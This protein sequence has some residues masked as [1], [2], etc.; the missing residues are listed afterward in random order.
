[1]NKTVCWWKRRSV[2]GIA[3]LLVAL[4]CVGC[5]DTK[6]NSGFEIS[7]R[8]QQDGKPI[9]L[10]PALA[11]VAAA[12]VSLDVQQYDDAGTLMFSTSTQAAP[13]GS[14]TVRGLQPGRYKLG[15]SCFNGGPDDV[16]RGRLAAEK[17]GIEVVLGSEPQ[18]I[19]LEVNDYLKQPP[20]KGR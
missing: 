9:P 8:V 18:T 7:G 10:D 15:I 16:F 5:S 14:F 12:Y 11:E 17:S 4:S 20:K 6:R 2:C 13:D 19:E 3:L 1:M